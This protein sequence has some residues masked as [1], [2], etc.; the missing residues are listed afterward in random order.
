MRREQTGYVVS[1]VLPKRHILEGVWIEPAGSL[2]G[3]A[4]PETNQKSNEEKTR[5]GL[6][7]IEERKRVY[8]FSQGHS[9]L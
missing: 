5:Q 2:S 3:Q 6:T 1:R 9:G 4:R 7:E 8:Y